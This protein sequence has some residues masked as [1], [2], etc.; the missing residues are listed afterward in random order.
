MKRSRSTCPKV[1]K[2]NTDT[3]V[4]LVR[5]IKIHSN[6]HYLVSN[7]NINIFFLFSLICGKFLVS[8]QKIS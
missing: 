1:N 5:N 8:D 7:N 3:P 2:P 6:I 4:Y